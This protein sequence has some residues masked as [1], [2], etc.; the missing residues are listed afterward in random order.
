MIS[1]AVCDDEL[2]ECISISAKVR[3]CMEELGIPCS[4]EQFYSGKELL[5]SVKRF[6]LIFL[7]ILMEGMDGLETARQCRELAFEKTLRP[8]DCYGAFAGGGSPW[9]LRQEKGDGGEPDGRG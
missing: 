8:I 2:L 5:G 1:I 3:T 7:D 4:I 6:D 9:R